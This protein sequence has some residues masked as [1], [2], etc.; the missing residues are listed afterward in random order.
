MEHTQSFDSKWNMASLKM[1]RMHVLLQ[2]AHQAR[3]LDRHMDWKTYLDSLRSE[4]VGYM[5]PA[6]DVKIK[7]LKIRSS[8]LL[9]DYLRWQNSGGNPKM[10]E[11]QVQLKQIDVEEALDEMQGLLVK[12]MKDHDMDLPQKDDPMTAVSRG[13]F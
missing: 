4:L 9:M 1:L 8:R 7:S 6:E 13:R 5:T 2:G 10:K 11:Y 12:C 3:I